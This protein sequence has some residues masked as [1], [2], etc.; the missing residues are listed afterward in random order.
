MVTEMERITNGRHCFFCT[1]THG[2]SVE[3]RGGG[4]GGGAAENAYFNKHC[5]NN[6]Q[7]PNSNCWQDYILPL[8]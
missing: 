1:K 4:K 3:V 6:M 5:G 7:N 2:Q 8:E